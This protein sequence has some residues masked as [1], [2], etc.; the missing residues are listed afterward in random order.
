MKNIAIFPT[1]ASVIFA[2]SALSAQP[3][4]ISFYA[5]EPDGLISESARAKHNETATVRYDYPK[6]DGKL[7]VFD[8][9]KKPKNVIFIIGDGM[10]IGARD[11]C[12]Y[13]HHGKKG[14]LFMESLPYAGLVTTHSSNSS[15]TDSAASGTALATGF[16]TSN[17]RIGVSPNGMTN[18]LSIASH[19]R[20]SGYKVAVMTDDNLSGATPAA[21]YA[22]RRERGMTHE[23]LFDLTNDRFDIF[24][25]KDGCSV[26]FKNN[27]HAKTNLISVI[28]DTHKY[29]RSVNDF[30]ESAGKGEK[31][32][33]LIPT[34]DF[35]KN[36]ADVLGKL[37]KAV[38]D[39]FTKDDDK[40]FL[41][42]FESTKADHGAHSSDLKV[43]TLG[44]IRADWLVKTAVDFAKER[45]DTLVIVT[46]DHETGGLY[47]IK[48]EMME[49]PAVIQ[50]T[51]G[52]SGAPVPINA[53]GPGAEMFSGVLDNT[54]I[55]RIIAYLLSLQV[56]N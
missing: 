27:N 37:L 10:G 32:V 55:P 53:F 15:V 45:D 48:S 24:L 2:V 41:I 38:L 47:A 40:P 8:K 35:D 31:S 5:T 20:R 14:G 46:A 28:K 33:S 43:N 36:G 12:S 18:Y 49:F 51:R 25:G 52:H 44:T 29:H 26:A 56:I 13:L 17:S 23:I 4:D 16:K 19:A 7:P 42:V 39:G 11:I 3:S 6:A 30:T 9:G 21:F 34:S 22:H 1:L 50:D 54:D